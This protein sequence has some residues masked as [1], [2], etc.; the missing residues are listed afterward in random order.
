MS[1]AEV[2]AHLPKRAP[3]TLH[4]SELQVAVEGTMAMARGLNTQTGAAGKVSGSVRFTD[5][6][7]YRAHHWR[8]IA[9]QETLVRQAD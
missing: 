5:V 8:A 1:R 6:F 9:A 2:L 7:V 4:L 3:S